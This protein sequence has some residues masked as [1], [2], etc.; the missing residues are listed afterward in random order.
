MRG[1]V[2]RPLLDA[3]RQLPTA[4]RRPAEAEA[5]VPEILGPPFQANRNAVS[6]D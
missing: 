5:L 3:A 4:A 1:D 6:R 2:I